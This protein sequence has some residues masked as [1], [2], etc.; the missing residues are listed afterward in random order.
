[1]TRTAAGDP[2]ELPIGAGHD[3]TRNTDIAARNACP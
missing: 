1:M 3:Q 2:S